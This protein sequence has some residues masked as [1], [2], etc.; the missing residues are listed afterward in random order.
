MLPNKVIVTGGAGVIGQ[1]ICR[2]LLQSNYVPVV[3]DLK[4][5]IDTVD[6]TEAGLTDAVPV[7]MDVTDRESVDNAVSSV[8]SDG[9]TV[10]GLVNCRV[11]SGIR[12]SASWTRRRWS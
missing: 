10:Y 6:F 1:A 3:A 11:S 5:A 12:S 4:P 7:A 9:Q 2:R 8:V